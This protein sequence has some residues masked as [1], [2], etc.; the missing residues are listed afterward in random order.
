M[1]ES[2]QKLTYTLAALGDLGQELADAG[3]FAEMMRS[4]LHAVVGALAIRR[5]A[6]A[7]Y[8]AKE[9]Q[10]R[11]VAS[12]GGTKNLNDLNAATSFQLDRAAIEVL[13]KRHET[14]AGISLIRRT[15]AVALSVVQLER[16]V[17]LRTRL[18]FNRLL[19]FLNFEL[20]VPLIVR[21]ELLGVMMLGTKASGQEFTFEECELVRTMARQ[22]AIGLHNHRLLGEV[23]HRATE[24]LRLYEQ[25][26]DT[27]HQ[28]VEAFAAAIDCK[29]AYTQGH[30][31]RVGK[32][33]AVIARELGL[34]DEAIE[35][36]TVAGY[37][38][39]VGKLTV[40]REILN[41]P[42]R[43]ETKQTNEFRKHPVTG[44]EI[45]SRIHHPYADIPLMILYHH[46]RLDGQ[47]YPEGLKGEA[48][49]LGAKII[50]LAD[51][52]DAMTT[53][54]PYRRRRTFEEAIEELRAN[55][56]GQFAPEVV[57]A[58]GQAWLKELNN[59]TRDKTFARLLGREYI[60]TEIAKM[61][62][63]NLLAG[64]E[65]KAVAA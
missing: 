17:N 13:L 3:E 36:V 9:S 27:Y 51:S 61:L 35:G 58:F 33:C 1:A 39:D 18:E 22:L 29:D 55:A 7:E 14:R 2:L 62:L 59:K 43:L 31:Q 60:N 32:Y 24:N 23:A 21:S 54:R 28:T 8:D 38:H 46:E 49:P 52:F 6:V 53:D 10:L 15:D 45:L 50:A 42:H 63:T 11:I 16:R 65:T 30:S 5:G 34:S 41:A 64:V 12:R 20:I 47:G 25:L 56:G 26:R 40:D 4:T 19:E 57:R 44:Y 37:L 48:I